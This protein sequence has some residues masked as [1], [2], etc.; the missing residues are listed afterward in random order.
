MFYIE[1]YRKYLYNSTKGISNTDKEEK[2]IYERQK[3]VDI[4]NELPDMFSEAGK[5]LQGASGD[6][7][8]GAVSHNNGNNLIYTCIRKEII[9]ETVKRGWLIGFEA[10]VKAVREECEFFLGKI[11]E[12]IDMMLLKK[13]A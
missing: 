6:T 8:S 10:A 2:L 1:L 7:G 12:E 13:A 4:L 3:V 9:E 11:L 5:I